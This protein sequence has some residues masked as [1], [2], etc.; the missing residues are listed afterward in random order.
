MHQ[1]STVPWVA[2]NRAT[3]VLPSQDRALVHGRC[4]LPDAPYRRRLTGVLSALNFWIASEYACNWVIEIEDIS[5]FV[6]QQHGYAQTTR[7]YAHLEI[8]REDIY[9]VDD[10][11][12]A[13]H[14]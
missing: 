4:Y 10:A 8:P 2:A 9:P 11:D 7:S 1:R 5:G 12:I 14:L 6:A 3:P 13:Q